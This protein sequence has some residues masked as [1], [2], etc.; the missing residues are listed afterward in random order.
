MTN[1]TADYTIIIREV[2]SENI[3]Y[4]EAYHGTRHQVEQRASEVW[5]VPYASMPDRYRL[6]VY[7][8]ESRSPF[9]TIG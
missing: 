4:I 2:A 8:K 3:I 5:N 6:K 1:V 9:L 7:E